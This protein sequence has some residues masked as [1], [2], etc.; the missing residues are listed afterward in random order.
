[1]VSLKDGHRPGAAV[2]VALLACAA[3]AQDHGR[4]V[5]HVVGPLGEPVPAAEV[6]ACAR[7]H[8]DLVLAR[9]RADG[10]G[11]FVLA[12]LPAAVTLHAR[13]ETRLGAPMPCEPQE[14]AG[15]DVTLPVWE[16][17][18]LHGV[19]VDA[20][21]VPVAGV[22]VIAT[23]PHNPIWNGEPAAAT[24]TDAEGRWSLQVPLGALELRAFGAGPSTAEVDTVLGTDEAE[25]ELRLR[26]ARAMA[27]E[28]QVDGL[29]P[30][31]RASI[32][33]RSLIPG[34]PLPPRLAHGVTDAGGRWRAPDLPPHR[35]EVTVRA[36]G[37]DIGPEPQGVGPLAPDAPLRFRAS[38]GPL[39]LRGRLQRE[40]G[41][42]LAGETIVCTTEDRTETRRTVTA[43]DGTFVLACPAPRGEPVWIGL[44]GA[45]S[46][47]PA[48][49]AAVLDGQREMHPERRTE[50]NRQLWV[51]ASE[52]MELVATKGWEVDGRVQAAAGAPA[53]FAPV[54]LET[55]NDTWQPLLHGL[56][57]GA[58]RF[59][60]G[61]IEMPSGELRVRV[62]AAAGSAVTPPL[63]LRDGRLTAPLLVRLGPVTTVAGTVRDRQGHP[64]PGAVVTLG[65]VITIEGG[66]VAEGVAALENGRPSPVTLTDRNGRYRFAVASPGKVHLEAR[67]G[68]RSA[69]ARLVLDAGTE[70]RAD[71]ALSEESTQPVEGGILTRRL[72]PPGKDDDSR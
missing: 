26:P 56:T 10:E 43:D 62:E 14:G 68:P 27:V 50:G 59:H 8:G 5:G 53:A 64:M 17:G 33:V 30:G 46:L 13:T 49:L 21:G 67:L 36:D 45:W 60:L 40:D 71:L 52:P 23:P 25:V 41:S 2:V 63:E 51:A 32:E 42:P 48:K 16:A 31:D 35:F 54:V 4:V 18:C 66:H 61:G 38:A 57:D 7:H 39:C 58:G 72:P 11:M 37:Y 69:D 3:G 70:T 65:T 12:G 22:D 55:C 47:Q 44:E 29:R 19:A 1:M 20:Q 9:T 24:T 34:H 15:V 28:V 6:V